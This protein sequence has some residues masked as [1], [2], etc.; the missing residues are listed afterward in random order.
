MCDNE[1]AM[2]LV[3]IREA[4]EHIY[5]L[6]VEQA[7]RERRSLSQQAL[8]ALARGLGVEMDAKARR[9]TLLERL[10]S[11]PIAPGAKFGSPVK[12]IREDRRR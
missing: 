4:P 3:Q 8:A 10:R 6:L 2:P 5:R 1:G 9:R 11:D 12:L 7:G